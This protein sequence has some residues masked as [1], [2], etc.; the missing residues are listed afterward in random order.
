MQIENG[1]YRQCE[2][3]KGESEKRAW[4]KIEDTKWRYNHITI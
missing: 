1:K 3:E 4:W 2:E